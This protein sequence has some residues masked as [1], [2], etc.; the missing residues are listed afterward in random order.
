MLL[1]SDGVLIMKVFTTLDN[2]NPTGF[3]FDVVHGENMPADVQEISG[4]D[5]ETFIREPGQWVYVDGSR[6]AK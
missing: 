3:Y 5:Y 1:A 4:E 2:G 6:R